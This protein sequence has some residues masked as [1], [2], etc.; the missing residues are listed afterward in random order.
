MEDNDEFRMFPFMELPRGILI[1]H[2]AVHEIGNVC[3]NKFHLEGRG[4]IVCDPVTEKIAA[5]AVQQSLQDSGYDTDIIL[6]E[7]ATDHSVE[8][9]NRYVEKYEKYF[10]LGVG[11]GRPIDVA[12][13]VATIHNMDFISVPTAA[14]HDGIA[15]SR[16]SIEMDGR[17][18][19]IRP[20]TS[21]E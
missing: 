2:E 9:V 21:I 12:K 8:V 4:L 7:G 19:S 18:K 13:Y 14:S 20:L 1:K 3:S 17:K 5:K 16:S 15:S 11:G 10:I 6:I